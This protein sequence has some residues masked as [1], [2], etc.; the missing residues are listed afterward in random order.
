M[1]AENDF[2]Y[3]FETE[4]LRADRGESAFSLVTMNFSS[5]GELDGCKSAV[6]NVIH[7]RIREVD[8]CGVLS[9]GRLGLLAPNTS[10][11]GADALVADLLARFPNSVPRPTIEIREH[12]A[13]ADSRSGDRTR[14]RGDRRTTRRAQADTSAFT[15]PM[16]RWKRLIDVVGAACGIMVLLPLFALVS[17]LIKLTS[18]GPVFYAQQRTGRAGKK[19]W[20]YK[21]RTMSVDA[22][23]QR[24][25]LLHLNEQDGPAFK[26]EHDPRIT[27]IGHWLRSTSVDELPQLWNILKGDMSFVGPRPLPCEEADGCEPWQRRRLGVTPGLTCTWQVQDRSN[28][29]PFADW[30][31]M[32]IRYVRSVSL[33]KDVKLVLKTA[34]FLF[35]RR[36]R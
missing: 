36:N 23:S 33:L 24:D 28:P 17:A 19:F 2:R 18:T 6:T 30:M 3:L 15:A 4:R 21:F 16:P 32:D 10:R 5:D 35:G 1:H 22:E 29:V 20:I 26:I 13:M 31:R 34:G 8:E 12:G 11:Q 7:D 9:A 25:E 14:S 27:R